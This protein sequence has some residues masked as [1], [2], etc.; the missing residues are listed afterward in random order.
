MNAI[1]RRA[2]QFA[3]SQAFVQRVADWLDDW[4]AKRERDGYTGLSVD[5]RTVIEEVLKKRIPR[6]HDQNKPFRMTQNDWGLVRQVQYI[7]SSGMTSAELLAQSG[8]LSELYL[9]VEDE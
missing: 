7:V 8:L 2:N 4:R 6:Y 9:R 5:D 3:R 1:T